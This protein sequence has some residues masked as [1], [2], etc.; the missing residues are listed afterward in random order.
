MT[1]LKNTVKTDHAVNTISVICFGF[2]A[3][4]YAFAP[5]QIG[6]FGWL[7]LTAF[8]GVVLMFVLGPVLAVI[9]G[10]LFALRKPV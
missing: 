3:L 1:D 8:T 10:L 4:A 5:V 6:F 7:L 2:A 9:L